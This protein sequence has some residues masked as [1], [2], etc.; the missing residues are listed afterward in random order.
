MNFI[1]KKILFPVL[2]FVGLVAGAIVVG[3]V[4]LA[5]DE[6]GLREIVWVVVVAGLIIVGA[7][8]WIVKY[9][10]DQKWIRENQDLIT[11]RRRR[12]ARA[13]RRE[14]V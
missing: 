11:G 6:F 7:V 12:E 8:G 10:R 4:S 9:R 2:G 3:V 5:L 1:T 14:E 13:E